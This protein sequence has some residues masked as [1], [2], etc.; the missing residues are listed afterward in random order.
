MIAITTNS[1]ISVKAA[2]DREH[3]TPLRSPIGTHG[4]LSKKL[5]LVLAS[6]TSPRCLAP[7]ACCKARGARQRG[8]VM[9]A[10][11]RVSFFESAPCVPIGERRGVTCS[12]SRAAF[13]LIELLVVI[14]II[15]VLVELLLPAVQQ[16]RAAARST[17]CKNNLKQLTLAL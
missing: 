2:R 1:S 15:A 12:R 5:T 16:A 13:T 6:M 7:R 4:A 11:T 3:V 10:R 8:L 9:L 14:A 17:Q